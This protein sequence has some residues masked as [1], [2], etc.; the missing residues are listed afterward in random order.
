[1][2]DP[3]KIVDL[4]P[5]LPHAAATPHVQMQVTPVNFTSTTQVRTDIPV[6]PSVIQM[7]PPPKSLGYH[8]HKSQV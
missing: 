8:C 5:T 7:V 2:A 3:V 1:M 4:S 6:P